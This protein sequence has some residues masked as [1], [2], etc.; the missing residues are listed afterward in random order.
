MQMKA[1]VCSVGIL[2][3]PKKNV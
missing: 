3:I 2:E 1:E